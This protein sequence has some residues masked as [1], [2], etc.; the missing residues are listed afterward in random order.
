MRRSRSA[1][2][3]AGDRSGERPDRVSKGLSRQTTGSSGPVG[4]GGGFTLVELLI[5]MALIALITLLLFSGLSLGSRAWEGVE[6]VAER[7]AEQRIART[8]L[9][10]LLPQARPIGVRLEDGEHFLFA[11]EPERVEFVAPLLQR[12]GVPGLY[13]LRLSLAERSEGRALM[14][15]WWLVH[16]EVLAGSAEFPAWEPLPEADTAAEAWAEPDPDDAAAGAYGTTL[17]LDEV[18]AFEIGYFGLLPGEEHGEWLEEWVDWPRLP[19]RV[20]IQVSTA[21]RSWPELL[22]NLAEGNQ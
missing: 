15:T 21:T 18:E 1:A 10:R 3:V 12:V 13:L 5:A 14:L 6:E 11:G 4:A 17:L 16:P 22:V 9:A 20:R 2:C 7:N 8:L 19:Q